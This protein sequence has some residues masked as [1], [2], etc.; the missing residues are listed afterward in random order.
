MAKVDLNEWQASI[1]LLKRADTRTAYSFDLGYAAYFVNR[2]SRSGIILGSGP[3]GGYRQTGQWKIDARWYRTTMSARVAWIG[4]AR[5]GSNLQ[6]RTPW[7]SWRDPAL[8]C[9]L[10][11]A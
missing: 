6:T 3:I 10:R 1:D 5:I 11:T 7:C 8:G 2:T 4:T 9:R